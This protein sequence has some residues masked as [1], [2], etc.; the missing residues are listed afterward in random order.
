MI[1]TFRPKPPHIEFNIAL[2]RGFFATYV[3]AEP[4]EC[5]P[6]GMADSHH[7]T[8]PNFA[9]L[10]L[11]RFH[12]RRLRLFER[13]PTKPTPPTSSMLIHSSRRSVPQVMFVDNSSRSSRPLV[14]T[15][16]PRCHLVRN[17][18]VSPPTSPSIQPFPTSP[19]PWSRSLRFAALLSRITHAGKIKSDSEWEHNQ[20]KIS[21][22][23]FFVDTFEDDPDLDTYCFQSLLAVTPTWLVPICGA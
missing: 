13:D 22:Y 12:H 10:R 1:Q 11:T 18:R 21:G 6:S 23:F 15:Y 3:A 19:P 9:T 16:F 7:A 14:S 20:Y 2:R 8:E 5:W 4:A 17:I